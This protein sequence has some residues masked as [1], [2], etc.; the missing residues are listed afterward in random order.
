MARAIRDQVIDELLQGYRSPED[1]LGKK[2][3][4]KELNNAC[5]NASSVPSCRSVLGGYLAGVK[6]QLDHPDESGGKL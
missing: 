6:T 1:L 5:W 4:F 2:G 3:P